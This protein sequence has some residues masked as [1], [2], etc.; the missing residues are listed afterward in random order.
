MIPRTLPPVS[1]WLPERVRG[2]P[3]AVRPAARTVV[4][5][6]LIG[7]QSWLAGRNG[8]FHNWREEDRA[9]HCQRRCEGGQGPE[10]RTQPS[11]A[12][13]FHAAAA[14][15]TSW[16]GTRNNAYAKPCPRLSW[17]W[18]PTRRT[19]IL[20]HRCVSE[21]NAKRSMTISWCHMRPRLG[22]TFAARLPVR[23]VASHKSQVM[24][25]SW[26][27]TSRWPGF[28]LS[29]DV[30]S[31]RSFQV[32]NERGAAV[33]QLAARTIYFRCRPSTRAGLVGN[34]ARILA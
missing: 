13:L 17:R 11:S 25:R 26:S 7:R 33:S 21:T 6:R 19:D 29:C 18:H 14:F 30:K 31:T 23:C 8:G 27:S 20:G 3:A 9:R 22:D 2:R 16:V 32:S 4:R 34:L 1:A 10:S 12:A 15:A 5:R 28:P 24:S